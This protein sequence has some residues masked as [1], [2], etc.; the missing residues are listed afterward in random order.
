MDV[1][2]TYRAKIDRK[3]SL[4]LHIPLADSYRFAYFFAIFGLLTD[5]LWIFGYTFYLPL[6][7]MLK[8]TLQYIYGFVYDGKKMF[9][10]DIS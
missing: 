1:V 9:Y 5:V 6:H 3:E 8:N 10:E 4:H 7:F 2:R